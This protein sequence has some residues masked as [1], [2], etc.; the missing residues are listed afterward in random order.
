M[1][2]THDCILT[3]VN[4][5]ISDNS[6][7]TCRINGLENTSPTRIILDKNLKIPIKSYIVRT[8]SRYNTIIFFNK[9]NKKKLN[10]LKKLKIKLISTPLNEDG[11]F[12]LE[13]VLI[14][15]KLLGFSRIF[16]ESGL[17]MTA[18]FLDRGLVDVFQLF[19]SSKKLNLDGFNSFESIMKIF[20][21]KNKTT[22]EKVNL[23][24]DKLISYRVK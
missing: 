22:N 18:N 21:K 17:N 3:S 20:L 23:F 9:I 16:L 6:K 12:N 24:G 5:I 8:A 15:V 1:R 11:N 2:S 7:L 19:I 13:S 10:F 14:K 4:T